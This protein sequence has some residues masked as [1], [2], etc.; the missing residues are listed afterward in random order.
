MVNN[1]LCCV[2][3][4]VAA[5]VASWKLE[6]LVQHRLIPVL[7]T[8]TLYGIHSIRIDDNRYDFVANHATCNAAR[9]ATKLPILW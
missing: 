8:G 1:L 3:V 7:R 2:T 6:V 5:V 4:L 9:R